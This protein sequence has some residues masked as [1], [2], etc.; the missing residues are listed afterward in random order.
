MRSLR[1]NVIL[2]VDWC[3]CVCLSVCLSV[4]LVSCVETAD[5]INKLFL[6]LVALII[7]VFQ[8]IHCYKLP[9]DPLSEGVKHTESGKIAN[10]SL[11]LGNST[12]YVHVTMDH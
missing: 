2:D 8:S 11:Y 5:D 1:I 4:T 9:R 10:I 7:L 3:V 6:G 12:R